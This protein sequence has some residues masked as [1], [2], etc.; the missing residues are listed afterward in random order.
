M[1]EN[2]F[3]SLREAQRLRVFVNS[4]QRRILGNDRNKVTGE[5]KKYTMRNF[6]NCTLHLVLNVC[7]DDYVRQIWKD[8]E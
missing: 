7:E 1:S 4:V 5:T 3:L 8:L 6:I 2:W